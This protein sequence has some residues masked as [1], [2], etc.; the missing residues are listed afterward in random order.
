[1]AQ[2]NVSSEPVASQFAL[3]FFDCFCCLLLFRAECCQTGAPVAHHQPAKRHYPEP[4]T[5]PVWKRIVEAHDISPG[6]ASQ[7]GPQRFQRRPG[8]GYGWWCSHHD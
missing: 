8:H 6:H 2:L 3:H 1:M 7:R 5:G 4:A